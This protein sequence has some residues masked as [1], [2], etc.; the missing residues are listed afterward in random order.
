VN[1]LRVKKYEWSF[2][3]AIAYSLVEQGF[4][5][6]GTG[7]YRETFAKSMGRQKSVIKVPC[8]GEGLNHNVREAFVYR[9]YRNRGDSRGVVYAPCRLLPSGCLLMTWVDTTWSSATAP[10]A[11]LIDGYQVGFIRGRVVA[12]DS[13]C[14]ILPDDYDDADKWAGLER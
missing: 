6:V 5:S 7:S 11:Y 13:G 12:F 4:E 10:W 2:Y 3:E 8:S 14:D 1:P 9:K